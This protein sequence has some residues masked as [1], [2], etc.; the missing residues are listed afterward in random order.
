LPFKK[1]AF[2]LG[3]ATKLPIVP[4]VLRGTHRAWPNRTFRLSKTT[5]EIEFLPPIDT[6]HWTA[7]TLDQHMAELRDVYIAALPE[8][9][10]PLPEVAEGA[11]DVAKAA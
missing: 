11:A 8:D 9:Q 10:R 3:L 5:V 6:S 7:E 2:H 1:G 4:I